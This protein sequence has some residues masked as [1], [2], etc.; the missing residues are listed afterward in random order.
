MVVYVDNANLSWRDKR[1][2]H[3]IADDQSELHQF[4]KKLGLKKSW[5]QV[6]LISMPHYDITEKKRFEAINM[7]AI[8]IST[9][10]IAEKNKAFRKA[11]QQ[12]PA[13]I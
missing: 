2:F 9:A 5:Y 8:P 1:W 3:L 7:G 10:E 11:R 6:P 12:K 4:A 13:Q